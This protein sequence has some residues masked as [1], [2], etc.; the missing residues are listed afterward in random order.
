VNA[1]EHPRISSSPPRGTATLASFAGLIAA[2]VI[3]SP[4]QCDESF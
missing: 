2:F 1:G 4:P 3:A